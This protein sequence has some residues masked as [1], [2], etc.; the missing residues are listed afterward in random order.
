MSAFVA[1]GRQL[2]RITIN[3]YQAYTWITQN[4]DL[5]SAK[6]RKGQGGFTESADFLA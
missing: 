4:S 2:K 3:K 6:L 1:V 5:K